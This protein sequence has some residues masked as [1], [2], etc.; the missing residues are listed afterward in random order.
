LLRVHVADPTRVD[1]VA[2]RG[3]AFT[4]GLHFLN[5]ADGMALIGGDLYVAFG[6]RVSRVR[7]DGATWASATV[8]T[9]SGWS[10]LTAITEVDGEPYGIQGQA[11][12]RLL[13]APPS[14]PFRVA[15]I[16]L[17]WFDNR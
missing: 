13:R 16:P 10:G 8:R 6:A 1:N 4:G 5:G 11:V 9:L 14:R 17:S 2:L 15:R 12:R 3:D 7:P